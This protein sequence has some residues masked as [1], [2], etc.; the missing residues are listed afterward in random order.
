MPLNTAGQ[1]EYKAVSMIG[2]VQFQAD[3]PV[4][5]VCEQ[6]VTRRN[7]GAA[8]VESRGRTQAKFEFVECTACTRMRAY[9]DTLRRFVERHH[10]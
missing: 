10:L 3:P 6:E 7:F 5:N 8:C 1:I 4:C 2:A 9:G